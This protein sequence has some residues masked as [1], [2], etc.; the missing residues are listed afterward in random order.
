LSAL[1]FAVRPVVD[2]DLIAPH[3]EPG[4]HFLQADRD[5]EA[6]L[7][8]LASVPPSVLL[9]AL[10]E[11]LKA[12]MLGGSQDGNEQESLQRSPLNS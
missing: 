10:E 6:G 5:Q 9:A 12:S 4:G 11:C 3:G 8:V 1:R 7:E 2:N